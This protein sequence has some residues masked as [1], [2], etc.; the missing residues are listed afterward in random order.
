MRLALSLNAALGEGPVW[1]MC[2]NGTRARMTPKA[3]SWR[4]E[5]NPEARRE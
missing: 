4:V 3:T 1:S 2:R 5:G